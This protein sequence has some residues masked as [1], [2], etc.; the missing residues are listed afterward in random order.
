MLPGRLSYSPGNLC[1]AKELP[2]LVELIREAGFDTIDFWLFRYCETTNAPMFEDNWRDFVTEARS[3]I[4]RAGV[5][6]GQVH[7]WWDHP[8]QIA[9]DGSFDL[10]HE[11]F[12]RNIEACRM[13]GSDKLVFHPIQRWFR[14]TDP[15]THQAVL[16]A[17][18]AWF[19][20]L[21]PAAEAFGVELHIENLFDYQHISQPGDQPFPCGSAEDILYVINRIGHPLVKT[22]LDTGHANINGE[23]V[24]RMIRLYGDKLGSLH[25]QDNFG[26][27]SPVYED[28][29]MFPTYG[30]LPWEEIFAAL[31]DIGYSGTLNL[32]VSSELRRLPDPIRLIHL[33]AGH[34][35]LKTLNEL[36]G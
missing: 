19:S 33:R 24:P 1:R 6:V 32:E 11:I 8:W 14:S 2:E 20:A 18:V 28:L 35:I 27:I 16:D 9:E 15:A 3:I 30:R 25:L 17:N 23:D 10:P 29:H 31:R 7:A 12:C 13:L 22:C 5:T 34:D 21:L 26:K 36:Y 4:D